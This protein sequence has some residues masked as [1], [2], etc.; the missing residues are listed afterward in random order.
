MTQSRPVQA[1]YATIGIAARLAWLLFGV[2]LFLM[3]AMAVFSWTMYRTEREAALEEKQRSAATLAAII[4][5]V[6]QPDAGPQTNPS[7]C[8]R[9]ICQKPS[10][11]ST[12][13]LVHHACCSMVQIWRVTTSWWIAFMSKPAVWPRSSCVRAMISS[14]SPRV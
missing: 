4:G 6:D 3:V 9:T 5:Q 2:A 14:A 7:R 11:S 8:F 1:P 12:N 10:Y 13:L